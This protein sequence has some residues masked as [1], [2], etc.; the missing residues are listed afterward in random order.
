MQVGRP[1]VY[2]WLQGV[3]PR[4]GPQIRLKELRDIATTW[5]SLTD[6]PVGKY[7]IAP[8]AGGTSFLELL[9]APELNRAAINR[10]MEEISSNIR[11]ADSRKRNSGYVSAAKI[12]KE[13]GTKPLSRELRRERINDAADF[14]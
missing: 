6:K 8:L 13:G 12:L 1:A 3:N 11:A 2:A 5:S 7:L 14:G 10:A 9:R 4:E